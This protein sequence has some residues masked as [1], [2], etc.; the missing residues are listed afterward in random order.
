MT[1][2]RIALFAAFMVTVVLSKPVNLTEDEDSSESAEE[3]SSEEAKPHGNLP[4]VNTPDIIVHIKPA[5]GKK[6]PD[7]IVPIKPAIDTSTKVGHPAP[8]T[9]I[10][11][12]IV[13]IHPAAGTNNPDII[14]PI[15]P[16]AGTNNPDIIVPIH[17]AQG[18]NNPDIIV[19]I[20]PAQGTNNPDIIVPIHSAPG[21]NNPDIIVP[22]EPSGT[23]KMLPSVDASLS[24]TMIDTSTLPDYID[25]QI[26][27]DTSNLIP[28]DPTAT[29]PGTGIFQDVPVIDASQGSITDS[30]HVLPESEVSLNTQLPVIYAT[31]T[32]YQELPLGTT[33]KP[34]E[35][36]LGT[37]ENGVPVC[38]TFQFATSAPDPPRGDS[39]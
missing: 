6:I 11:D 34:L 31:N 20:H 37:V 27:T 22:I 39:M 14:V 2:L 13:P 24:P 16:A 30:M 23:I 29:T 33:A 38:F 35:I 7:T 26:F 9:N 36:P 19:P 17:P 25:P 15:H 1:A 12:I 21:T 5:P 3:K 32:P 10:P 28:D 4:R 8:G 18:T